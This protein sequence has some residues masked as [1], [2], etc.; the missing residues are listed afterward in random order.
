MDEISLKQMNIK[1]PKSEYAELLSIKAQL[2][3]MSI[4]SMIRI[5]IT[6]HLELARESGNPKK[7]LDMK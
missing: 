3:G 4:S 5:L 7:F 1:I 2:G 6:Q